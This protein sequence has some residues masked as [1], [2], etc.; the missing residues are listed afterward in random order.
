M[1]KHQTIVVVG[2]LLLL[3][4]VSAGWSMVRLSNARQQARQ[5]AR[6]LDECRRLIAQIKNLREKPNIAGATEMQ[7]NDLAAVIEKAADEAELPRQNLIRI[8]PEQARRIGDTPYKENQ[9]RCLSE[10]PI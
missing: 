8:W 7:I 1:K 6:E 4:L 9:H 10:T 5:Q 3:G 2:L